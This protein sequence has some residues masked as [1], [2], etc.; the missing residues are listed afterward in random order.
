[1]EKF[2]L[3]VRRLLLLAFLLLTLL[4]S[5]FSQAGFSVNGK[6][7][8]ANGLPVEGV[9]VQEKGTQNITLTKKDGTFSL[10]TQSGTATL[11][12]SSV[13]YVPQEIA[14]NNQANVAVTMQA[15]TNSL[16]EVV[17]VGYGTQRKSDVTGSLSRITADVIQ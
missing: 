4:F 16:N 9:T 15:T 12:L 6:I 7:N 11:L 14:V 2:S 10:R 8:D 3:Y 17:V 5:A 1:M 13:G